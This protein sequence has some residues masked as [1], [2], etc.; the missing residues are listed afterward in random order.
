MALFTLISLNY[1]TLTSITSLPIVFIPPHPLFILLQFSLHPV[2][3]HQALHTLINST[4][5]PL[6][7]FR[8]HS[9]TSDNTLCSRLHPIFTANITSVP[10]TDTFAYI[11]QTQYLIQTH[12]RYHHLLP[13]FPYYFNFSS[14]CVNILP[15]IEPGYPHQY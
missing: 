10:A 8:H 9:F 3:V 14:H 5:V 4:S 11:I 12:N 7:A 6:N 15:F 2:F 13:T 1:T